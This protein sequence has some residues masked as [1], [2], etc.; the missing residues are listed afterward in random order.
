MQ[1][2]LRRRKSL[3]IEGS[4]QYAVALTGLVRGEKQDVG[5]GLRQREASR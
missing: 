5:S 3:G 1:L 2:N 4:S